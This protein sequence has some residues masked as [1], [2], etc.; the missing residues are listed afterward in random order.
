[1][2]KYGMRLRGFSI[3]CQPMTG[4]VRRE[5]DPTGKYHDILI[6]NRMLNDNEQDAFE[7]DYLGEVSM[8]YI[9]EIEEMPFISEGSEMQLFKAT[10]FNSLVF[11]RNGLEKLTPYDESAAEQRG[12]EEAWKLIKAIGKMSDDDMADCFGTSVIVNLSYTEAREKYEAWKKEKEEIKIGDEVRHKYE[13]RDIMV[14]T[15]TEP[16][17]AS[18]IKSNGR[19]VIRRADEI[20]RTGR[21]FPEVAELLEKMRQPE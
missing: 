3:G 16:G 15:G 4:L 9:I 19:V 13:P 17:Y 14:Y 8:K 20:E 21:H 10:E 5:G 12:R 18:C 2:Y 7:L 6:Y 1:M 11:D